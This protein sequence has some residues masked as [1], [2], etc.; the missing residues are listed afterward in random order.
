MAQSF[1]TAYI[2]TPW[3]AIYSSP[4]ARA[5]STATPLAMAVKIELQIRAGLAEIDYGAWEGQDVAR[6]RATIS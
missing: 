3:A 5:I 2:S 4:R 6:A 1:A